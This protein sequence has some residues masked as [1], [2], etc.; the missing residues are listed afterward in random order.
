MSHCLIWE[1]PD[2][3]IMVTA[4][5]ANSQPREGFEGSQRDWWVFRTLEASPELFKGVVQLPDCQSTELPRSRRFRSCWRNDGK[6][7]VQVKMELARE[8]R[9]EEIRAERNS[10]FASLDGEWMKAT[11]QGDEKRAAEVEA[12][13]QKLRDLPG[14]LKLASLKT[15]EML[16]AFEPVWPGGSDAAT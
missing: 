4:C 14:A 12:V 9:T 15:P 3:S 5:A 2:G 16:E 8:Q 11:G 1:K 10:R 6:G 7:G 13:R